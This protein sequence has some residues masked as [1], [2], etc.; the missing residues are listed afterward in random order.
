MSIENPE[1]PVK[2]PGRRVRFA[3]E[4]H[5]PYSRNQICA[6][7][8]SECQTQCGD[9]KTPSPTATFLIEVHDGSGERDEDEDARQHDEDANGD[10]ASRYGRVRGRPAVRMHCYIVVNRPWRLVV[11]TYLGGKH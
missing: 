10:H 6:P 2:H 1:Y 3:D 11:A 9:R 7:V 5:R 8:Q 4:I